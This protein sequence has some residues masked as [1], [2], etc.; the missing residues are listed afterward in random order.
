MEYNASKFARFLR[1]KGRSKT[2]ASVPRAHARSARLSCLDLPGSVS[3]INNYFEQQGWTDELPIIPPTEDLVSARLEVSPAPAEQVLGQLPPRNGTVTVEKVAI[4]AVIAGCQPAY[5]PV[6]LAAVKAVLQP[7]F[8]AGAITTTTGGA[9]PV[10]V[11]SGPIARRIGIHSG[12]AVLGSG[13]RANATIGRA[14]RLTM[15]NLGGHGR[16][17]GEIDA[18]LARGELP[19]AS[20]S[21]PER[22]P[23]YAPGGL[24][25]ANSRWI[26]R[27][28]LWSLPGRAMR[29]PGTCIGV[30]PHHGRMRTPVIRASADGGEL[31]RGMV[32]MTPLSALDIRQECVRAIVGELDVLLGDVTMQVAAESPRQECRSRGHSHSPSMGK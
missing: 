6:V 2:M 12:T 31:M 16:H 24:L 22:C 29:H 13:H 11:V 14:L 1:V 17:H 5:F 9:A 32:P 25:T 10:L 28:A 19:S 15:R 18:S 7:Q 3:D 4:N 20:R 21:P 26:C 8:N 30:A 27:V 23:P